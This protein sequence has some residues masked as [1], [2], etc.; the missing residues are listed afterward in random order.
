MAVFR[1]Q[2]E[3]LDSSDTVVGEGQAY[4]HLPRGAGVPQRVQGTFSLVRWD[5][6]AGAP[7]AIRLADGRR[8]AIQVEADRLNNCLNGGRILRYFAQWPPQ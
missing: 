8:L 1:S 7:A 5:P 4:I 3:L 6:D 2:A